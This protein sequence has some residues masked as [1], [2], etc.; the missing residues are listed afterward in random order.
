MDNFELTYDRRTNT[1]IIMPKT[2]ILDVVD[3]FL[4][5]PTIENAY[6]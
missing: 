6:L 1:N 3:K 2:E 4:Y 5:N